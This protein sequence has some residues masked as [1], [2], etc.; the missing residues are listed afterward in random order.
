MKTSLHILSTLQTNIGDEFIRDGI[1]SVLHTLHPAFP[2]NVTVYNK[3]QPWTFYPKGHPIRWVEP[4]AKRNLR[5]W[6]PLA[7][8]LGRIPGNRFF[9]AHLVI[10]SG[11][12]ILW[13]GA[14]RSEWAGPFWSSFAAHPHRR[15]PL[16]NLGGGSC[17]SW[18]KPPERL[19]GEDRTFARRMVELSQLLTV[20]DPLA[21]RLLGEASGRDIPVI[22]CP[23]FLAGRFHVPTP[24]PAGEVLLLNV[25]PR[26]GHF[27]YQQ[28]I[29]ADDWKQSVD[30]L[31]QTHRKTFRMRFVCH[32]QQELDFARTQWPEFEAFRPDSPQAYFEGCQGAVAAVTNR[33][34][35]AV[36]LSGL[37]IPG[38]AIGTDTRMLMTQQIGICTLFAPEATPDRLAQEL[39]E[40]LRQRESLSESLSRKREQVMQTYVDLLAKQPALSQA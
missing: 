1:L 18:L 35:A 2:Y 38:I 16:F 4:L 32:S 17:Y 39:A 10:Q 7:R 24:A 34:H 19:E 37:G 11:T 31:I 12:P 8:L 30:H 15:A 5:G 14:C 21:A 6:R 9:E 36:G 20:R 40:I 33:L 29:R 13:Q 25:M 22:P 26:A 23:A 28:N 27:D 3:H